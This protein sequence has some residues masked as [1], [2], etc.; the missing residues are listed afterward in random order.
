MEEYLSDPESYSIQKTLKRCLFK[1]KIDYFISDKTFPEY[2]VDNFV[3]L[4]KK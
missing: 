1:G 2:F 3:L 4:S